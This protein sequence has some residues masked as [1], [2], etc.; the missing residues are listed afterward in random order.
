MFWADRILSIETGKVYDINFV[1]IQNFR[2]RGEVRVRMEQVERLHL[3]V[4]QL[5]RPGLGVIKFV[6]WK[7]TT[8]LDCQQQQQ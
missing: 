5:L 6:A 3:R 1:Q 8:K 2:I 7:T 4:V